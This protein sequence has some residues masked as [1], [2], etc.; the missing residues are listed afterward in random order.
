MIIKLDQYYNI[1]EAIT[2]GGDPNAEM[3]CEVSDVPEDILNDIFSYKYI[4]QQFIRREDADEV[5]IRKA[6]QRKIQYLSETCHT[7]IE[8]G[9]QIND[10]HYSLTA[11]DQMNLSKLAMQA[12]M[13]PEI[14]LFYHPDG[15]LCRQ[16]TPEQIL[17]ISQLG[18]AWITYHT[19]YF[20]FAKAY[21]ESLNTFESIVSFQYGSPIHDPSLQKQMQPIIELTQ[22]HFDTIIPDPNYYDEIK[23]PLCGIHE[24]HQPITDDHVDDK[25]EHEIIYADFYEGDIINEETTDE[26]SVP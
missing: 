7:I 26:G 17:M 2:V 21:V 24:H 14:P 6:K 16:Y 1:I 11:T 12:T 9:I 18:V 22:V 25:T 15:G 23:Q 5:Y 10:E 3:C 13:N 19:T 20:N 8:Y 4:G